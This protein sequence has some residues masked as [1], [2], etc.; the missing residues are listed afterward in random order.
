MPQFVRQQ[1]AHQGYCEGQTI[2]QRGGMLV[3]Q[4]ERVNKFIHGNGFVM[5]EGH[6]ELR[7]G[8]QATAQ[9]H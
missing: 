1:D 7:S 6:G 5:C 8:N 3:Q 4:L 2:E 9:R